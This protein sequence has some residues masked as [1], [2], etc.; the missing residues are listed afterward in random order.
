MNSLVQY[1]YDHLPD[2]I[3]CHNFVALVLVCLEGQLA[4]HY[5]RLE[6]IVFKQGPNTIGVINH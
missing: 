6:F 4:A 1:I 2:D 5:G 3:F